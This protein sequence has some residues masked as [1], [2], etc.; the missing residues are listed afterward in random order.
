MRCLSTN[1]LNWWRSFFNKGK[2]LSP[3]PDKYP[4]DPRLKQTVPNGGPSSEEDTQD[5]FAII[6]GASNNAGKSFALYLMEKGFN[7]ILIERDAESLQELEDSL[8][9]K[10]QKDTKI[11]KIVLNKYD[12]DSVSRAVSEYVTYPVK[13]FVNCR[14]TKKAGLDDSSNSDFDKRIDEIQKLN[15]SNSAVSKGKIKEIIKQEE[16]INGFHLVTRAEIHF[17]GK[18]NMEGFVALVNMFIRTML[19]TTYNPCIINVDNEDHAMKS[20]EMREGLLFY[21]ATLDFKNSFTKLM[22]SKNKNL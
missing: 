18:E 19:L 17:T 3:V 14:S 21:R 6:Y 12:Q 16:Q 1:F 4:D 11:I 20:A 2:Y 5:S 10:S 7:L 13:I 22:G 9:F 15:T 8:K